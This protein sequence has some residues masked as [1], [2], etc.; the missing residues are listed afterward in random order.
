MQLNDSSFNWA[1]AHLPLSYLRQDL[2]TINVKTM[3]I[4]DLVRM[5]HDESTGLVR[6]QNQLAA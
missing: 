1:I 2:P 5:N 6:R 3:L 4:V